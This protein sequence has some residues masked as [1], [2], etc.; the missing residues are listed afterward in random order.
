MYLT[1]RALSS[2]SD[3]GLDS[4]IKDAAELGLLDVVKSEGDMDLQGKVIKRLMT[5]PRTVLMGLRA[6]RYINPFL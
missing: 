5:D 6:I 2:L 4:I 1:Q 3:R